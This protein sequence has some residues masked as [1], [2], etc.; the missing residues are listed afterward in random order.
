ME[1]VSYTFF[2][3]TIVRSLGARRR[4]TALAEGVPIVTQVCG[5]WQVALSASRRSP[6]FVPS[7]TATD[8]QKAGAVALPRSFALPLTAPPA[9][10]SSSST[11]GQITFASLSTDGHRSLTCLT[12]SSLHVQLRLNVFLSAAMHVDNLLWAHIDVSLNTFARLCGPW[13]MALSASRSSPQSVPSSTCNGHAEGQGSRPASLFGV[14]V[15]DAAGQASS[16]PSWGG[17]TRSSVA[18]LAAELLS[19]AASAQRSVQNLKKLRTR[20]YTVGRRK[21]ETW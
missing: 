18:S 1:K 2:S 19:F 5:L 14:T 12:L 3:S 16:S 7:S 17:R 20:G 15:D 6:Q 21:H 10:S 11:W 13:Q 9:K 8:A 4:C